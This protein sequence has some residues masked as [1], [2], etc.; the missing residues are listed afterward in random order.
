MEKT[1]KRRELTAEEKQDVARL[2]A[3]WLAYKDR[4]EGATQEWLGRETGIG[5]QGAVGQYLRGV[6]PLNLPA[7]LSFS[8]V[9]G[10]SPESISPTLAALVPKTTEPVGTPI[11]PIEHGAETPEG[12]VAIQRF[13][14]RCQAG[15]GHIQWEIDREVEPST[16]SLRYLREAGIKPQNARR[17]KITGDSM[18]PT[19]YDGDSALIDCGDT[20]VRDGKVYALRYG[21]GFRVKRILKKYDGS[22]VLVSD[23]KKYPEEIISAEQAAQFITILGRVRDRSGSGGLE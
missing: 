23:N 16:Y 8:R 2:K 12:Y 13:N 18:E 19:L 7:L 17:V 14:L 21:D 5:S 20:A 22:I 1:P 10:V 11:I 9:L 6:I 15:S 3:A 4:N